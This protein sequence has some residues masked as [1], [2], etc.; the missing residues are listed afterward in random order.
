MGGFS[1]VEI[2]DV[3]AGAAPAAAR[4]KRAIQNSQANDRTVVVVMS[5]ILQQEPVFMTVETNQVA[6]IFQ[7]ISLHGL[8]DI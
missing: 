6:G 1:G 2:A 4:M 5:V 8:P 3:A 7:W